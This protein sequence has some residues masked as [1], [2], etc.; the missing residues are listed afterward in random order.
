MLPLVT[1]TVRTPI[2][3][4]KAHTAA[5]GLRPS[6]PVS[7][8][9]GKVVPLGSGVP[10]IRPVIRTIARSR[11]TSPRTTRPTYAGVALSRA[12]VTVAMRI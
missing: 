2:G 10:S 4:P 6:L 11:R 8:I 7:S 9:V 1:F 12:E 5:P 3:K